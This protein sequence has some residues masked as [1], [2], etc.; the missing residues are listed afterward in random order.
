MKIAVPKETWVGETR[1]AATP[2]TVAKFVRLGAEVEVEA[3]VGVSAGFTDE[4]Y[5]KAGD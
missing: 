1:A 5:I 4:A 2:E 3:G